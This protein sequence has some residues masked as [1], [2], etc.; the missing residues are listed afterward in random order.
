M[1][2][3]L[4]EACKRAMGDADLHDL[5]ARLAEG[6]IGQAGAMAADVARWRQRYPA[7]VAHVE[8]LYAEHR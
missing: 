8:R 7:V 4:V 2:G 1:M 6:H 5:G 3:K